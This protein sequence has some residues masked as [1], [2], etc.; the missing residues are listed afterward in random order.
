M[1]IRDLTQQIEKETK[2]ESE[3]I[4]KVVLEDS[5]TFGELYTKSGY[6][7]V[8]ELIKKEFKESKVSTGDGALSD[9]IQRKV[10][11][12]VTDFV[13]SAPIEENRNPT[14]AATEVELNDR[15]NQILVN[16]IELLERRS[17]SKY[18]QNSELIKITNSLANARKTI[19]Y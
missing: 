16:Q 3:R 1:N 2:E 17:Q 15:I 10:R 5:T 6:S 8:E 14:T 12:K 13:M 11:Q 4:F 9:V 19:K 18:I 7:E